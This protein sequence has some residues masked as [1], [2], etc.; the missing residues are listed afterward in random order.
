MRIKILT[1][2]LLFIASLFVVSCRKDTKNDNPNN[3]IDNFLD[4]KVSESFDFESFTNVNTEINLGTTKDNGTEI[5][6]IY[7]AHPSVGG[8]LILTGSVN[9]NGIF[10][11][12]I[13]LASRFSEVYV[14][15]L[16]SVGANEYIPVNIVNSKIQL[17]FTSNKSV[18]DNDPCTSG[19]LLT[20]SGSLGDYTVNA[21]EVICIAENTSASINKLKIESGG[22]LR[23]CGNLTVQK[24]QGNGGNGLLLIN[25]LGTV[26]LPKHSL[27]ID[28]ENY[29]N[30]NFS[31]G[32][33]QACQWNSD[34]DNWGEITCTIKIIN[35]GTVTND[36]EINMSKEFTNNPGANFINNCELKINKGSNNDFKQNSDFTNN[37]YVYVKGHA[38]LTGSS[39]TTLGLGSLIDTDDF[40]IEGDIIGPNSQGSQITAEE[41]GKTTGGSS[42]T[43]YVDLCTDDDDDLDNGFKGPNV[44]TDCS[45]TIPVPQCDAN[46][47]PTITSSLQLGGLVNQSITS[48]VMTATGTET[49]T[50]TMGSL[51]SVLTFNSS[52]NT[53]TGTPNT[54][55]TYNVVMT[56]SN[57]MG[58][59]TK[60]LVITITQPTAPPVITSLLTGNTTV[61]HTYNYTITA[62]GDP[63]ITYDATNLPVGLSFAGP[64]TITGIPS[65]AGT[66]NINLEASNTGGTTTETLVLTVGTPPDITST[67]TASGTEGVQFN[68]YTVFATGSPSITYSVASLPPGLSFNTTDQTINGTPLYL[69]IYNTVLTAVN[70][71]G[72]NIKTLVITINEGLQPPSITSSLTANAQVDS[73]FSYSITADGSQSITYNV[74]TGDM[75]DGLNFSGNT[76][77]GIPTEDGTF[78]ITLLANNTAGYDEKVLVLTVATGGNTDTDGDGI[79]DNLDAYINDPT[80]AFNSYYPNETDYGSFAFEDLWPGYG[81]YD[82]NDFVV[83]FNY[84]IVTNAQNETVDVITNFQIMAAGAELNNGFGIVFDAPSSAVGSVTGCLKFGNAVQIDAKGFEVGHTNSTVIIPFDAI[85]P[86]MEGG[87]VNTVPGGRYIQTTVNTITTHFDIPQASIGIPPFNPFIFVDQ[88]RGYEI[89]LKNQPPTELVD[90]DYFDTWSDVSNPALGT[91]YISETGLPWGIEVPVNFNYPIEKADILTAYIKFAAWAQSSGTS[92]PDWYMDKSGYRNTSNIYVIP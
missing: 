20:V 51:P 84:K 15:K 70:D 77:S 45:Y 48:Y 80:R 40:D 16:S 18:A 32:G 47:A 35:K 74:S 60:T 3:D 5:I 66:Y 12:P 8:K 25:E 11:I 78:N 39:T 85:N 37:G 69:G 68:T 91:Y 36:G 75:P 29:G 58:S 54:V 88:E 86:I 41:D 61:N 87:I 27:N 50:Y 76:I 38:K 49:I 52:N 23:V 92:Y 71:Y 24:Y 81:D 31:G 10:D 7:D 57:F 72:T 33:N 65:V 55:G 22:T 82:F 73:H 59:D 62:T 79:P 42:I 2:T 43:G 64:N 19:C 89:H 6:Q 17:D 28:I 4:L 21:N 1:I 46:V 13:R 14:G 83:N 67:L 30:L 63:T 34:I 56:A 44:T 26:N 9:E 90:P 53:I